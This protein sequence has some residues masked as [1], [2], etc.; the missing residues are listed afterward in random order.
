MKLKIALSCSLLALLV[1]AGLC[2]GKGAAKPA[3]PP[4]VGFNL[5]K[6]WS[7]VVVHKAGQNTVTLVETEALVPAAR[8]PGES[9]PLSTYRV[10][11]LSDAGNPYCPTCGIVLCK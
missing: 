5:A 9:Y 2:L 10:Y 7:Y 1:G 6:D 8:K 3:A 11:R 4:P